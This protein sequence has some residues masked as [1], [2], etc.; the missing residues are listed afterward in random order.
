MRSNFFSRVFNRYHL[1]YSPSSERYYVKKG[2]LYLHK[3]SKLLPH[4]TSDAIYAKDKN[5]AMFYILNAKAT[6][7]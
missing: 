5:L 7:G 1:E 6:N 4:I 3:G 2:K